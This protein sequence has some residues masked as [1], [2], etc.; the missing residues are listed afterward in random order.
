MKNFLSIYEEFFNEGKSKFHL[1]LYLINAGNERTFTGTE[2]DLIDDIRNK[3]NLPI[4]FVI[5]H[6]RTDEASQEFKESV[7]ISLILP[8]KL[9][10]GLFF[11]AKSSNL[12]IC[13]MSTIFFHYYNIKN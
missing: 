8:S 2:L 12:I 3:Y 9:C 1:V 11:D 10:I 6:S 7:K 13:V 5:T 4:F